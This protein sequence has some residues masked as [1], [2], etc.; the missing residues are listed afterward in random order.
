LN[1]VIGLKP[2]AATIAEAVD[3]PEYTAPEVEKA[4]DDLKM[5]QGIWYRMYSEIDGKAWPSDVPPKSPRVKVLIRDDAWMGVDKDG[6]HVKQHTIRLDPTQRPKAID[7][8][9]ADE[10]QAGILGI[11][12]LER[13]KL[14]LCLNI[15][16]RAGRPREFAAK[17]RDDKEPTVLDVYERAKPKPISVGEEGDHD[18]TL[19]F[20]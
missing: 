6:T 4:E 18:T 5:L 10:Q 1:P 15:H 8:F 14:T 12:K 13:D 11:Y 20:D 17:P 16:G 19:G 3:Q 2:A 7:L 9:T